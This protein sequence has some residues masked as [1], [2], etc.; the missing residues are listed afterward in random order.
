MT[1]GLVFSPDTVYNAYSNQQRTV[2]R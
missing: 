2:A 1:R